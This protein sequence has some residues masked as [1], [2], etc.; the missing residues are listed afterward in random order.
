[1]YLYPMI[2]GRRQLRAFAMMKKSGV[3]IDCTFAEVEI[4]I[5]YSCFNRTNAKDP[6]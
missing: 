4:G 3:L 1:M 6:E 5:K 2:K